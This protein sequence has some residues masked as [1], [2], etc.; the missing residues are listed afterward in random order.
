M[1]LSKTQLLDLIRKAFHTFETHEAD[2]WFRVDGQR[3]T[4]P[5]G[6]VTW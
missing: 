3:V 6:P 2:E 5:H 1:G 4:N